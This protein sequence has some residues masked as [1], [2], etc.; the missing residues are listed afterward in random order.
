[1]LKATLLSFT[2]LVTTAAAGHASTRN[3]FLPNVNG[4]RLASCLANP[5]S[6]GKPTADAFCVVQGF[7]QAIMFQREPAASTRQLNSD[8][9][10]EGATCISFRLIKCVK[11]TTGTSLA[12]NQ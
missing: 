11:P 12:A 4:V 2:I 8:T 9:M 1:M 10:C 6:R 7:S 3:Y 5:E